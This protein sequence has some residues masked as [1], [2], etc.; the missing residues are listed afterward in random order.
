[1]CYIYARSSGRASGGALQ[2]A[3]ELGLD[4]DEDADLVGLRTGVV[5]GGGA[6]PFRY[7]S[8]LMRAS[9]PLIT[10]SPRISML[11]K[12]ATLAFPVLVGI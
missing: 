1:M 5:V 6:F 3:E 11:L 10:T 2:A 12:V 9:L 8:C 7:L 4:E